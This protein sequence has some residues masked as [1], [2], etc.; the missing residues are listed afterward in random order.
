MRPARPAPTIWAE[1][2]LA[3]PVPLAWAADPVAEPEGEPLACAPVPEA[4][5]PVDAADP[6]ESVALDPALAAAEEAA[7]GAKGAT[8]WVLGKRLAKQ[9]C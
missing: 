8:V 5:A 3:A 9:S 4:E 2:E 7:P 6:A 1:L